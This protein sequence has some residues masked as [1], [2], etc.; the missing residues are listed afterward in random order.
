[1]STQHT[2]NHTKAFVLIDSVGLFELSIKNQKFKQERQHSQLHHP[3]GCG[4]DPTKERTSKILK[5]SFNL[6][7]NFCKILKL[8][9]LVPFFA[10][11]LG[12]QTEER[13]S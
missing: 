5:L 3:L 8:V 12:K 10:P 6:A 11:F 9:L 2:T 7:N 4:W 1:L 13:G